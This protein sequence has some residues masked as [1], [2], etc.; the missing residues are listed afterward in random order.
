MAWNFTDTRSQ[1]AA[2]TSRRKS[3]IASCQP[4]RKSFPNQPLTASPNA[5][6][7]S[8]SSIKGARG[9]TFRGHRDDR[10]SIHHLPQLLHLLRV[11]EMAASVTLEVTAMIL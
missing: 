7:K 11:Q 5:A 9:T 2:I 1:G 10:M 6:T 8:Y 3:A 4:S